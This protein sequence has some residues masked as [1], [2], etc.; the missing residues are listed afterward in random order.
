MTIERAPRFAYSRRSRG[1][2]EESVER[3]WWWSEVL[4]NCVLNWM[5]VRN[6]MHGQGELGLH[7]DQ[8]GK[9]E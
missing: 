7:W 4:W 5:G 8:V 2:G 6:G 3:R 9:V 1:R